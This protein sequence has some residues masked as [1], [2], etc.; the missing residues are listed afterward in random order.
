[1][2][3]S[4]HWYS[5]TAFLMTVGMSSMALLPLL[6][7]AATAQI[8]PQA[9]PFLVAQLF[10]QQPT[11]QVRVPAGTV[12]PV[13]YDKAEKIIV[14]P[15][16]TSPVTLT[17]A[18]DVRSARGTVLITAGSQIEGELRP[19]QTSGTRFFSKT[20]TPPGGSR[21]L[22]INAT[23]DAI[24][25]TE[26]INRNTNPDILKGAAIGAAAGAILGEIFGSI[27]ILEVLGGAG[28]GALAA[29]LLPHREEVEVVVINPA[30]DLN[31]TLQSDFTLR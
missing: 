16:E 21:S 28:A 30:T 22:D 14:T 4:I 27:D 26:T 10:P 5:K 6:S 15:D 23:S 29:V 31:L 7:S 20:L 25:T 18:Q 2:F 17:V 1:M 9:Q 19:D 11:S 24:T 12:I 3:I 8:K 13:R